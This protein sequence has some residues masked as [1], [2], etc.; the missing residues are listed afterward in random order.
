MAGHPLTTQE[1]ELH[2]EVR[3]F[4]GRRLGHVIG[5]VSVVDSTSYIDVVDPGNGQVLTSVPQGTPEIVDQAV[6]AARVALKDG[7]WGQMAPGARAKLLWRLADRIEE[8][9]EIFAQLETLDVGKPLAGSLGEVG[10]AVEAFR[11]MAGWATKLSGE[12]LQV[13]QRGTMHAFTQREPIGVVGQIVP[14]N[15]PLIMAAWKLAPALAAGCTSVLKPADQTPLTAILLAELALE[16]GLPAG[17]LNVVIGDGKVTGEALVRHRGV[18]KIAFTGSTVVGKSI[19]RICA[20]DLKA[21]TLELGGKNSSIV[22]PDADFS[23]TVPGVLQSA[24]GNT[25]QICTAPSRILVHRDVMDTFGAALAEAASSLT[26]GHGLNKAAKLGPVVSQRQLDSIVSILEEGLNSG[27][28]LLAGGVVPASPGF[29]LE[30]TVVTGLGLDNP[31]V[32]RE[33]FGPV[34][35]LIPFDTIDEAITMANDTSYGLTAQVWTQNVSNVHRFAHLLESGTV[36]VNGKSQDIALPFGGYKESGIGLE[37]GRQ[38]IEAYTRLKTVV[39][40]L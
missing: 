22:M 7:P 6:T 38:G 39:V 5:G 15:F 10:A 26:L 3:S 17:V 16:A 31:M 30:P 27:G 19:V 33:I 18:D 35:N 21:V 9:T 24:F 34:V 20:D 4:L 28:Q 40:T 14:W 32:Q 25:G 8:K 23:K 11:Y 37:K 1:T 13:G 36:W 12:T 2:P 29:Y